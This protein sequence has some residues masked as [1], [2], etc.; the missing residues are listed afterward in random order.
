[1]DTMATK[2]RKSQIRIN[3]ELA[4][5]LATIARAEAIPGYMLIEKIAV[6][7]IRLNKPELLIMLESVITEIEQ[8]PNLQTQLESKFQIVNHDDNHK[9]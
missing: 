7:W 5:A 4:K 6:D 8:R 9:I 3:P 1:M 2:E